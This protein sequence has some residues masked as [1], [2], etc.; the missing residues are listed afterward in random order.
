MNSRGV[1][2][3]IEK[4][5]RTDFSFVVKSIAVIAAISVA[6]DAILRGGNSVRIVVGAKI[7]RG[8]FL[9]HDRSVG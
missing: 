2:D 4:S 6:N 5:R 9:G 8:Y 3:G 7:T 1:G